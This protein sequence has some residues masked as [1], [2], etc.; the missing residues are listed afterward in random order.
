M[1][2]Y[3][4]P[5][6]SSEEDDYDDDGAGGGGVGGGGF[7]SGGGVSKGGVAAGKQLKRDRY[8]IFHKYEVR[9]IKNANLSIKYE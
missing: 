9:S 4:R 1:E 7:S 5:D 8:K 3:Q 2:R 6:L